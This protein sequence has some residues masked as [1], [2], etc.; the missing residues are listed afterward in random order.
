MPNANYDSRVAF[1]THQK[2]LQIFEEIEKTILRVG[3]SNGGGTCK[4]L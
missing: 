2:Q 3:C 1:N 4:R